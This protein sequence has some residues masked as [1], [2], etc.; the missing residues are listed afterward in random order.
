VIGEAAQH[1]F[2]PRLRVD[3]VELGGGDERVDRGC[4]LTSAVGTREQPI[5]PS[6][7]DAAQCSFGGVVR[8]ANPAVVEEA[9]EGGPALQHVLHRLGDLVVPGE[10]GPLAPHPCFQLAHEGCHVRFAQR[11]ALIFG[12]AIEGALD[13]ED[14]VDPAHGFEGQRRLGNVRQHEELAPGVAPARR[15]GD[16]P[17]VAAQIV[18]LVEPG[19][20]I[21]LENAAVVD[22][23]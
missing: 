1:V 5:A 19:E 15:L 10:P 11:Q 23:V 2:E 22:E 21:G 20:R 12:D 13:I 3:V 18:E 9:D 6:E 14:G 17:G 8:Q 4:T 16:R 7:G